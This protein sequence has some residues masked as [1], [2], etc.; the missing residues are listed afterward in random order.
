MAS[1]E[2]LISCRS[3]AGTFQQQAET[4]IVRVSEFRHCLR[5]SAEAGGWGMLEPEDLHGG[6]CSHWTPVPS[7]LTEVAHIP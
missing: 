1:K 3:R 6:L 7:V 2:A 5:W 4:L